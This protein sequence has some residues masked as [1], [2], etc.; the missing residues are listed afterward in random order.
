MIAIIGGAFNP[1]TNSHINLSK[2]ILKNL[3]V[4][5]VIYV[6]VGDSYNKKELI[7]AKHRIKML[8]LATKNI[9]N[10]EISQIETKSKYVMRTIETLEEIQKKYPNEIIAFVMGA[11]KLIEISKWKRNE[12]L[13]YNFKFIVFNRNSYDINDIFLKNKKLNKYK[14]NFIIVNNYIDNISST[15][16]RNNI[17]NNKSITGIVDLFVENYILEN[18]L[19]KNN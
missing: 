5:K 10:V 9:K 8:E 7:C 18:N 3:D 1:P 15:L 13:L 11:D 17:K 6:P 14:E 16:I 4:T 12:E 2:H 19:Y